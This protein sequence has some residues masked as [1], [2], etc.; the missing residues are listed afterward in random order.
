MAL[1]HATLTNVD[2][3]ER[4]EVLFNPVEY[5]LN[6]ENNFAEAAIRARLAAPSVRPRKPC[7]RWRWSSFFDTWR[8]TVRPRLGPTCVS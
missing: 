6:K 5:S 8:P 7:G 3:G 2:T 4:F 1:E